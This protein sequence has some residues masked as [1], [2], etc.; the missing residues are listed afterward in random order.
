MVPLVAA[1]E[2]CAELKQAAFRSHAAC[3]TGGADG[4]YVIGALNGDVD[5]HHD[6]VRQDGRDLHA[7]I[8]T[9][10]KVIPALV[11]RQMSQG[12]DLGGAFRR[13]VTRFEGSVAIGAA[14]TA[15]PDQLALA[16]RG[17][18]QALYVGFAEDTFVVASEPY[19]VVEDCDRYLRLDGET[20]GNPD[21]PSGSRGQVV[22]LSR[23]DAGELTGVARAAYDGTAL[24][25]EEADLTMAEVTTRDI[26]R[27][28]YPHYLLKEIS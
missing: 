5:N 17:S 23:D 9:D 2:T 15:R 4:P 25:V 24:P 16:L 12:H 28:D 10:A 26:D 22:L 20:P 3:Y 19:G 21:N 14:S 8:T 7:A 1:N 13:T 6:L 27:G 18:G 11:S